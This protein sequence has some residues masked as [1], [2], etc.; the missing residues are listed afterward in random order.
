MITNRDAALAAIRA[1]GRLELVTVDHDAWE[2]RAGDALI[3]IDVANGLFL[4]HVIE[5]GCSGVF[6]ITSVAPPP[7]PAE[8]PPETPPPPRPPTGS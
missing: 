7:G 2:C 8:A 4:D 3:D 1:A 5:E 6:E